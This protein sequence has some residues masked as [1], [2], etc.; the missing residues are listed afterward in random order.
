MTLFLNE[1]NTKLNYPCIIFTIQSL[2]SKDTY[3]KNLLNL[4]SLEGK[5]NKFKYVPHEKVHVYVNLE[6]QNKDVMES[7]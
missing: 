2:I 7:W 5:K 4:H 3:S 1:D 6:N